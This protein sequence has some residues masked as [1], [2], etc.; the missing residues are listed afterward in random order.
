MKKCLIVGPSWVGDMVMSQG[1]YRTLKQQYPDARI[2]VIAPEWCRQILDKMPE[3]NQSLIMPIG[4]GEFALK[5][6]YHIGKQLRESSYDY[7]YIL[8]NSFKSALI[9]FFAKIPNRIGWKGEMRYGLLTDCRKLDKNAFPRMIERYK[10]LAYDSK[11]VTSAKDFPEPF[12]YPKLSVTAEEIRLVFSTFN[13]DESKSYIGICPG[14]EFGPAKC[15]PDYHY[16]ELSKLLIAEGKTIIIFGSA[17]DKL[18]AEQIEN[19]VQNKL[20]CIN[21]AG[22]TTLTQVVG[23]MA[24]C[25]TIITNDTGL[26]HI[27]ASIDKPLIALYGPT[28]PDFT[29]PLSDK[30]I[31][32]RL[33]TGFQKI[34]RGDSE[35]GYHQ[36]LID[37]KPNKVFDTINNLLAK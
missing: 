36:S 21:L 19:S 28:S 37:I 30:A 18:I 12:L 35:Q 10:A 29:P 13:L 11:K 26:M 3:V 24:G 16:A 34:K 33:I 7:A 23:L 9:P 14:A 22:N 4:H 27:A 25:E 2:D 8:P 32:L 15:W 6:R 1:L 20:S 5:K 17:K 31:V